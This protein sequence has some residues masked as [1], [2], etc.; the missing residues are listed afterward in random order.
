[1]TDKQDSAAFAAYILHLA[2]AF[3][4]ELRI[5]YRQYFVYHQYLGLEECGH[6]ESQPE[7][8]A[9][10]EVFEGGIDEPGYTCKI[11]DLIEFFPDLRFT[12]AKYTA[13]EKNILAT[14]KFRMKACSNFQQ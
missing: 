9:G 1:M 10:A 14:G 7:L 12:N 8:H 13:I 3:F 4:L 5:T 6:C 11:E 2:H